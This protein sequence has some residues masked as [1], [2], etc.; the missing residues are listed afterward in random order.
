[1]HGYWLWAAIWTMLVVT[2]TVVEMRKSKHPARWF[3]F[4]GRGGDDLTGR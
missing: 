2:I 3:F 4:D 1:M